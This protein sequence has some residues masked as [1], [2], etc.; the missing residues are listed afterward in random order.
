MQASKQS[1]E[2]V[3]HILTKLKDSS[4]KKHKLLNQ[5]D[6][7][8]YT[9]LMW[10]CSSG[11]MEIVQYLCMEHR[12]FVDINMRDQVRTLLDCSVL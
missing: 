12:E 11:M 4:E 3:Q 1:I 9:T 7:G 8:G 6:S 5:Q 2:V 10:A